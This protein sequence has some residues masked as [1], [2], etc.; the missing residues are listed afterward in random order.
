MKYQFK[1]PN[2]SELDE[3][4]LGFAL[5][6]ILNNSGNY[7]HTDYALV[8][9]FVRLV[10][11]AIREYENGRRKLCESQNNNTA[12]LWL[13][14]VASGHFEVCITTIKRTI[15]HLKGIRSNKT[16]RDN[17]PQSIKILNGKSE[18]QITDMRNAIQHFD[19][20][21]KKGEIKKGQ[22]LFIIPT[23][24]AIEL[25][26]YTIQFADLSSWLRELHK[27]AS[28]LALYKESVNK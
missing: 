18:K 19:E 22:P 12:R 6:H 16:I 21:I 5:N 8:M 20:Q 28:S 26:A 9:N 17:L 24:T 14:I 11:L 23:E 2:L 13:T 4:S 15:G 1:A 27:C 3:L 25:G 10:D 7:N